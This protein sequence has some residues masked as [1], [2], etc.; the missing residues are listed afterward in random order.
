MRAPPPLSK[1][2]FRGVVEAHRSNNLP[3]RRGWGSQRVYA[4]EIRVRR[5]IN[6]TVADEGMA[7]ARQ[8]RI[9]SVWGLG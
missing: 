5:H 2:S 4:P 3:V 7:H 1:D 8:D 6:D 9:S